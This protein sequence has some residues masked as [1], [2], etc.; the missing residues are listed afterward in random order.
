MS[1]EKAD[2]RTGKAADITVTP[3]VPGDPEQVRVRVQLR[4]DN[5]DLGQPSDPVYLT[6]NP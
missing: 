6:A 3:T 4:K 5:T 1:C 2:T